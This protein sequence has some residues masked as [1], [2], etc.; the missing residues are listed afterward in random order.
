MKRSVF[1]V[2]GVIGIVLLVGLM[3][4]DRISAQEASNP[5]LPLS[6][7]TPVIWEARGN[8]DLLSP[9][10][11][12]SSGVVVVD[13]SYQAT[14]SG[15]LGIKFLNTD[16][17]DSH[18]VVYKAISEDEGYSGGL[19]FDV[20]S[21][22]ATLSPGSYRIQINSEGAWH[23]DVSQPRRDVGLELPRFLQGSGDGGSFAFAF[24]SGIV[25]IYYEYLGPADQSG[26]IFGIRL[27]KMDGSEDERILYDFVA[28]NELPKSGIA[29]VTVH[30][31]SSG[32]ITPGVYLVSVQSEGDW[33][34]ALGAES[35]T[36]PTPMPMP[37]TA[38]T[39]IPTGTPE[40]IPTATPIPPSVPDEIYDRLSALETLMAILQGLIAA[41]ESRIAALEADNTSEPD[42]TCKRRSDNVP[43][44]RLDSLNA[45]VENRTACHLPIESI[46]TLMEGD[47]DVHRGHVFA[48]AQG[49]PGG[50][51]EHQGGVPGVRSAQR[52]RAQDALAPRATGIPQEAP[53]PSPQA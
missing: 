23:V 31:S 34:I 19:A 1:T 43:R 28:A 21:E 2:I 35:F 49:V 29:S 27:Y 50:G 37:T 17:S 30:E 13:V 18:R 25:P 38:P 52:H 22:Y 5:P 51:D 7:I 15:I 53:S 36:T 32:D 42:S 39:E 6:H 24:Q 3:Q 33:R 48:R 44:R 16:G 20:H 26:S 47:K 10:F 11:N 45:A 4:F 46:E 14:S 40:S 41:L 9:S 12:L 8:G